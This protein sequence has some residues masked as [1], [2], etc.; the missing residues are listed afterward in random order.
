MRNSKEPPMNSKNHRQ[1]LN[2]PKIRNNWE[3][4]QISFLKIANFD[5]QFLPE[6]HFDFYSVYLL[7]EH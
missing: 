3:I 7:V 4:S 6:I 2:L 5:K 1:F